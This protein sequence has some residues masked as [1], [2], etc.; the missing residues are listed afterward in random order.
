MKLDRQ[1]LSK[2]VKSNTLSGYINKDKRNILLEVVINHTRLPKSIRTKYGKVRIKYG[3]TKPDIII[4]SLKRDDKYD[5]IVM[6]FTSFSG[7][8]TKYFA[9]F[10]FEYTDNNYYILYDSAIKI[11]E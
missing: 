4:T 2:F 1:L 8:G 9:T 5:N 11:N 6:E 7:G 3:C 10:I